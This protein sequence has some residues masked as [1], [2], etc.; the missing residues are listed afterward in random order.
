MHFPVN[1]RLADFF[2]GSAMPNFPVRAPEFWSENTDMKRLLKMR[3]TA[4]QIFTGN[5][6]VLPGISDRRVR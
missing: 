6:P 4:A 2:P 1:S 3:H 5:F